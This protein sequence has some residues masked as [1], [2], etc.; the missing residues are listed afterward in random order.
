MISQYF[1]NQFGL[2]S[3]RMIR[4]ARWKYVWNPVSIDELYDLAAD[5]WERVNRASDPAC[6]GELARLRRRMAAW[7]S[8]IGDPLLNGFTRVQL[9]EGRKV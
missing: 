8:G 9:E 7:L 2:F 6:A 4:D 3:Q 5:P 1:G